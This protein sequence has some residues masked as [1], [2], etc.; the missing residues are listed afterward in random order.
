MFLQHS[1]WTKN[2]NGGERRTCFWKQ[3]RSLQNGGVARPFPSAFPFAPVPTICFRPP[4]DSRWLKNQ[5]W[6]RWFTVDVNCWFFFCFSCCR[7]KTMAG[8]ILV[9]VYAALFLPCS[10]RVALF[11]F[12][13]SFSGFFF[14]GFLG[15]FFFSLFSPCV[16]SFSRFL[17]CFCSGSPLFFLLFF[18]FPS[19]FY[20][21]SPAASF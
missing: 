20:R 2:E 12:V 6:R 3:R 10:L 13:L 7:D 14:F 21:D 19:P 18:R 11:F 8:T 16:I 1:I 5:Q 15:W 9:Y 4:A 17:L